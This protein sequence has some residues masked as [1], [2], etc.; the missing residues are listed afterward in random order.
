MKRDWDCIRAILVALEDKANA[1][2]HMFPAAVEGF[3]AQNV[4]YNMRLMI[5]ANLIDGVSKSEIM[6]VAKSMTWEGH[7]LLDKIRSETMWNQVK[8]L[9]REKGVSLS[10]E[11]VKILGTTA[12]KHY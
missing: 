12:L 8:K 2:D 9:A 5:E 1:A 6:T 3:D 4:A 10:F 7:E 11:A